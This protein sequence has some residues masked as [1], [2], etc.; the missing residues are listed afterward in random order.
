MGFFSGVFHVV[1]SH[2][3]GMPVQVG[4]RNITPMSNF[5]NISGMV[6]FRWAEKNKRGPS[7]SPGPSPCWGVDYKHWCC[8]LAAVSV[9]LLSYQSGR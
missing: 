2:K 6:V 3:L 7:K 5:H 9:S 4:Q 8:A 1:F